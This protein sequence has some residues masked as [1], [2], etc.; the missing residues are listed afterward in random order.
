VAAK[1]AA[2]DALLVTSKQGT[3]TGPLV[4]KEAVLS[5]L[6][7]VSVDVGDVPEVLD[8]VAPSAWVAWPDDSATPTGRARLVEALADELEKVLATRMRSTGR[9]AVERLSLG[10]AARAVEAIYRGVVSRAGRPART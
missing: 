5:G 7:V 6:P 9:E 8:G 10:A 2:A 1:F 4:V 3:E